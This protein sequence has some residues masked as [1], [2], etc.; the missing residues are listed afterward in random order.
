LVWWWQR[1]WWRH[2]S[3]SWGRPGRFHRH[4]QRSLTSCS[5]RCEILHA[6]RHAFFLVDG[7]VNDSEFAIDFV[8]YELDIIFCATAVWITVRNVI[9]HGVLHSVLHGILPTAV[10]ITVRNVILPYG[11][12]FSDVLL[13]DIVFSSVPYGVLYGDIVFSDIIFCGVFFGDLL[14]SGVVFANRILFDLFFVDIVFCELVCPDIAVLFCHNL[15]VFGDVLLDI[16]LGILLLWSFLFGDVFF[17]DIVFHDDLFLLSDILLGSL[18]GDDLF[19]DIVISAVFLLLG[20]ILTGSLPWDVL[21]VYLKHHVIIGL[22]SVFIFQLFSRD[23]TNRVPVRL[24]C[25]QWPDCGRPS[26]K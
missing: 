11:V 23:D 17:P 14:F 1:C 16:I 3:I 13:D 26:W 20:D 24:S 4:R 9:L 7:H 21:F 5:Y 18:P 19:P 2:L 10:R 22:P 8:F 12:L 15:F 6:C 25:K